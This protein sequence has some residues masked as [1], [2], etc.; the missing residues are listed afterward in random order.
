MK[1]FLATSGSD[2]SLAIGDRVYITAVTDKDVTKGSKFTAILDITDNDATATDPTVT[3]EALADG[4]KLVAM[5]PVDGN[6]GYKIKAENIATGLRLYRISR[7]DDPGWSVHRWWLE[8]DWADC[9]GG[10]ITPNASFNVTGVSTGS[11]GTLKITGITN[12]DYMENKTSS[13]MRL[14]RIHC[15]RRRLWQQITRLF[16]SEHNG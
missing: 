16:Y 4:N 13:W 11:A 12:S 14:H 9:S 15:F 2:T 7:H 8:Y 6:Q 5:D 10:N 3:F 1:A